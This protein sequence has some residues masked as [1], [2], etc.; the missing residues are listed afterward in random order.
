MMWE[1]LV[2]WLEQKRGSVCSPALREMMGRRDAQSPGSASANIS[3]LHGVV[4][5]A[6]TTTRSSLQGGSG[7]LITP[8]FLCFSYCSHSLPGEV[9]RNDVTSS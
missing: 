8:G 7:F 3:L 2:T 4:F 1:H 6:E 9:G 5:A